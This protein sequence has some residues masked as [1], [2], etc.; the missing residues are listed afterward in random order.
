MNISE[1][2]DNKQMSGKDI[3]VLE[4]LCNKTG[5]CS[6]NGYLA[7]SLVD[8]SFDENGVLEFYSCKKDE[9]GTTDSIGCVLDDSVL[10]KQVQKGELSDY[11]RLYSWNVEDGVYTYLEFDDKSAL[12]T[13]YNRIKRMGVNL[14]DDDLSTS[15][16][17]MG[18]TFDNVTKVLI[19][20]KVDPLMSMFDEEKKSEG[21]LVL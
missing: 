7:S 6:M 12:N 21:S 1:F 5:N 2:K 15:L 20:Q 18:L 16:Q 3:N 10:I 8:C 9:S 14:C 19:N 11:S 13:F 4:K 17:G